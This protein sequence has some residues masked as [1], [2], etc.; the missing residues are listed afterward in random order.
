LHNLHKASYNQNA[1]PAALQPISIAVIF[2]IGCFGKAG[3]PEDYVPDT[4]NYHEQYHADPNH[5][6][7]A[8]LTGFI[9]HYPRILW[10]LPQSKDYG[11]DI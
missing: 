5:H 4:D 11:E 6:R 10:I 1:V 3:L 7:V 2:F 9:C 8:D